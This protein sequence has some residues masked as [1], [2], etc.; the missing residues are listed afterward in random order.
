[1]LYKLL[2]RGP[3]IVELKKSDSEASNESPI[4]L[5]GKKLSDSGLGGCQSGTGEDVSNDGNEIYYI[6]DSSLI[7]YVV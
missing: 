3:K 4:F 1:M 6:C 5:I 7:N 2:L